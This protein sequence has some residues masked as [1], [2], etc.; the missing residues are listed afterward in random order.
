MASNKNMKRYVII[1]FH[2]DILFIYVLLRC[3]RRISTKRMVQK[4]S[5]EKPSAKPRAP[6]IASRATT[7]ST[8]L[9]LPSRQKLPKQPTQN[10][11]AISSASY[12]NTP[13]DGYTIVQ[14][15]VLYSLM[16]K[17]KCEGCG[18]R[19]IGT[20]NTKKREGLFLIISFQCESCQKT[21]TI[22]KL[23]SSTMDLI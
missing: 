10:R 13:M 16:C 14:N 12:S 7:S 4:R 18:N 2:S 17:T 21:V 23:F 1:S 22:G 9:S 5:V 6:T 11:T 8:D 3:S 19:W 20:M 15:Q